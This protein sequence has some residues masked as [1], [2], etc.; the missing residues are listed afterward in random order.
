MKFLVDT[1]GWIEWLV[2]GKLSKNFEKYL[3]NPS[4]LVIP[5]IIQ[6]ELYKWVCRERDEETA[7]E[8]IGVT[9]QGKVIVFDTSLSLF[10]ADMAKKYGLAA[11]DAI[12]YATSRRNNAQIITCDKHF[13]TLPNAIYFPK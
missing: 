5:T 13:K 12:V 7:L 3:G 9:E 11:A 2:G 8:V 10:A 4:E 1:C 6:F